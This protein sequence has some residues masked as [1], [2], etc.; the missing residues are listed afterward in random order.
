[1]KNIYIIDEHQTSKRNG[2]G[3]FVKELI[4]CLQQLNV[5]ICLISFNADI[6][7]FNLTEKENRIKYMYFPPF[8]DIFPNYYNTIEKF[9]RLYIEDSSEN[10]FFF[11]HFPCNHLMKTIKQSHPLSKLLFVIHDQGWTTMLK[12]D[13]KKLEKIIS[14][15]EEEDVKSQYKAIIDRFDADKKTYSTADG[16][17]SLCDDTYRLIK[18]IYKMSYNLYMITNGC[19]DRCDYPVSKQEKLDVKE[20][21]NIDKEEKVLIYT[22]R[23]SKAKGTDVLIKSF[24]KIAQEMPKVRLILTGASTDK[25]YYHHLFNMS[26]GVTSKISFPGH[27]LNAD[28]NDWYKAADIGIFPSYVE[29][30]S[31]SGI[32]MMMYGLPIVASDGYGVRSMFI[33]GVNAKIANIGKNEE[34]FENNLTVSVI[35]LLKSESICNMLGR[36]AR[37]AFE[38]KYNIKGMLNEY[39]RFF[40]YRE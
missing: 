40:I 7:E 26:R 35:E 30:C 5:N 29:Q 21:L 22:G 14:K 16:L 31:Y 32:E 33:D 27:I 2:V 20:K 10:I 19:R 12:G 17:I 13:D 25:E 3:T 38:I 6:E 1:M 36:N 28:L 9:F 37:K 8:P 11:N 23:L 34:E 39:N 4:Y 15:R 18:D 24:C